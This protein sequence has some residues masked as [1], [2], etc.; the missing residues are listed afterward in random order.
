MVR[1]RAVFSP[2][3]LWRNLSR[4]RQTLFHFLLKKKILSANFSTHTHTHTK[5]QFDWGVWGWLADCGGDGGYWA[6]SSRRV[7]CTECGCGYSFLRILNAEPVPVAPRLTT[8]SWLPLFAAPLLHGSFFFVIYFFS[9]LFIFCIF[10]PF[11]LYTPVCAITSYFP[12]FFVYGLGLLFDCR[13]GRPALFL[14]LLHVIL[15]PKFYF[16]SIVHLLLALRNV[17]FGTLWGT[18]AVVSQN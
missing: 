1:R 18:T 4:N 17:E 5:V 12:F 14:M 15:K 11:L 6:C 8:G 10:C 13:A 7:R 9:I 3:Y 16:F 2:V